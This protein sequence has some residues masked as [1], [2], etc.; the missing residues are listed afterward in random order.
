[1][2]IEPQQE[3]HINPEYQSLIRPLTKEEYESLK[4]GIKKHG[5]QVKIIVNTE[6]VIIDGQHRYKADLELGITP[7]IDI[8]HFKNKVEEIECVIQ[9]NLSR[10]QLTD[11]DKVE[12][13]HKIKPI[14]Q[15]LAKQNQSLAGKNYGKGIDNSYVPNDTQLSPIGRVDDVVAKTVQLKTRTF[16]RGEAVLIQDPEAFEKLIKKGNKPIAQVERQLKLK[17]KRQQL[18]EVADTLPLINK[19]GVRLIQGDFIEKSK[20]ITDESIDLIFTDPPYEKIYL[21]L[22]GE[23]A[24]IAERI[25]KPGGSL[26]TYTGNYCHL[27]AAD[28]IRENSSLRYLAELVVQ[29]TGPTQAMHLEK[30]FVEHKSLLWFVKG[31]RSNAPEYIGTLI[32]SEPPDKTGHDWAQSPVEAEE[33]ISRVTR[34][35]EIICDPF[36]GSGTTGVAAVGLKRQFIGIEIDPEVFKRAQYRISEAIKGVS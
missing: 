36:M 14:Y 18:Q 33:V 13:G 27:Y 17:K 30:I 29:H 10:R 4:E 28:K 1:M 3:L 35:N 26:I 12:I 25:L 19:S 32:R 20:E 11:A 6:G 5:Q 21:P 31:T 34:S 23:L 24:K 2:T 16:Q 22:Y 8:I 15:E 9:C 7:D